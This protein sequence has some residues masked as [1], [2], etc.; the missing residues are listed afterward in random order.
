MSGAA[1]AR[2]SDR[3][4]LAPKLAYLVWKLGYDR[5]AL[6]AWTVLIWALL[7]ICFFFMPP[8]D[9]NAGLKPVN[10]NYVWGPKDDAAQAWVPPYIWLAGM[11]I[12][13]PLLLFW[14]THIVLLKYALKPA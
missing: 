5:G 11:M 13:L 8:P 1:S 12:G 3:V 4:S 7:L 14:P 2:A 10:I 6:P 9:P